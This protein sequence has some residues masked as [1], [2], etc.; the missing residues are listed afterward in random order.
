[1]K[2]GERLK[3]EDI[4][5]I[6][7]DSWANNPGKVSI[8]SKV[9]EETITTLK[10]TNCPICGEPLELSDSHGNSLSYKL[11]GQ[12]FPFDSMQK[13]CSNERY[14]VELEAH[15]FDGNTY[16]TEIYMR[17]YTDSK[18]SKLVAY[19]GELADINKHVELA[20]PF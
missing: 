12:C 3:P 6:R 8:D 5:S 14:I 2:Q 11:G 10:L 1:M 15:R 18:N 9:I 13:Y 7:K 16:G 20:L 17:I 4:R 19:S